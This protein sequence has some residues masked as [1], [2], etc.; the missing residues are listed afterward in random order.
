[1]MYN[2]ENVRSEI[3]TKCKCCEKNHP[4][5]NRCYSVGRFDPK[6]GCTAE[7]IA[8]G[9]YHCNFCKLIVFGPDDALQ[10][11]LAEIT[12]W[13]KLFR[14]QH[15]DQLRALTQKKLS[16]TPL[17]KHDQE[18]YDAVDALYGALID[19]KPQLRDS[20]QMRKDVYTLSCAYQKLKSLH[21]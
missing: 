4:C 12:D 6:S 18:F 21:I 17:D 2:H 11:Y 3:E 14:E 9:V 1:M 7:E 13:V 10:N 20:T 15:R 8:P 19:Y 16:S 5:G